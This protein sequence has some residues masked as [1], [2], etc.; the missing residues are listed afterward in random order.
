MLWF[1]KNGYIYNMKCSHSGIIAQEKFLFFIFTFSSF[2]FRQSFVHNI[3][4]KSNTHIYL[5]IYNTSNKAITVKVKITNSL[6]LYKHYMYIDNNN[7]NSSSFLRKSLSPHPLL[8]QLNLV[9]I[10]TITMFAINNRTY[11]CPL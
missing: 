7:I 1:Y 8:N 6:W 4:N 11:V 5:Q 3:E 2:R 10:F 9:L